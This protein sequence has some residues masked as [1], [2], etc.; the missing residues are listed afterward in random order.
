MAD[1]FYTAEKTCAICDQK[2]SVTRVRNR[3]SMLKQDSDFCTYYKEV[4]PYYYAI[5][6]CPHCGYAAQDNY[7]EEPPFNAATIKNFLSGREVKVNFGGQR[8]RQDAITTYK[9]AVY[10]ADM[11]DALPSRQAGLYLKLAWLYREGGLPDEETAM[12]DQAREY[13]E[14]AFLKEKIP[15]GNMS[16]ITLEYLI[17]E[18]LRRTGRLAEALN[19]L[20]KVVGNP[21]A[22]NEKRILELA[23]EAWTLARDA[24]KEQAAAAKHGI[25]EEESGA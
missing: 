22:K 16:Q 9:L 3:L 7:F 10:F 2:F 15:I 25:A 4:N 21:Q 14:K 23:R 20:S 11:A 6:V 1:I 13:Y 19:Y 17:G 12:L 18:L 24:R 5:W 8:T